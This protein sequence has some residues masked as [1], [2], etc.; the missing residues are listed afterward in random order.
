MN[1]Y[2]FDAQWER[3]LGRLRSLEA[4]FDGATIRYL[5]GLG[6]TQG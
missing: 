1:S 4:I 5:T 3:E 6:V 2:V